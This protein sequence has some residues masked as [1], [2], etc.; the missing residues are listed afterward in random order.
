MGPFKRV[1]VLGFDGLDP[2]V[3][4]TLMNRGTLPNFSRLRSEGTFA[5]LQTSVPPESPVAWMC[6]ATGMNPG[7]HGIFDFIGR[8][9]R[10]YMPRLS[11]LRPSLKVRL[12]LSLQAYEPPTR[13]KAFWDILSQRGTEVTVIR[14]P[15]TFPPHAVNGRMLS[16]LGTPDVTGTLGRYTFYTTAPADPADRAADRVVTVNWK[17]GAIRTTL[18]GPPAPSLTKAGRS[19][20]ALHIERAGG[21]ALRIAVGEAPAV[22]LRAG[23]WSGWIGVRFPLGLGRSCPAALRM[24]LSRVEPDLALYV[25]PLQIDPLDPAVPFTHPP[26]FGRELAERIGRFHTQG[27]P[28]DAQAAR[29]GRISLDA[30]LVQCQEITGERER[31]F[32]H[33]LS[34]FESGLLAAVFDTSDRIQHMFWERQHHSPASPQPLDSR[35]V[36]HYRRMD[37]VLGRALQAAGG[38]TALFVLSDHGFT[39]FAR[40]VH[41]N[42]WLVQ[43]GF[44]AL[45]D[46]AGGEGAPLLKSVDWWKTRAY[47]AGFCS[48]YLNLRGR[49]R[50]GILREGRERDRTIEELSNALLAWRDPKTGGPVVRTVYLGEKVFWGERVRE[51]P[52][53]VIGYHPGYRASWQTALGAAP[54]GDPLVDNDDL[55]I[56]DHLVDAPCVPGV[57]LSNLRCPVEAPRLVDIAP[58]VL[59]AFGL[60]GEQDMDGRPLL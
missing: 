19:S 31:M 43:N 49:E 3:L 21:D 54:A 57:F 7:R 15:V 35:I 11:I 32:E 28:E 26:E 1:L 37:K 16:G 55:W 51:A 20:V 8:D 60:E 27:L 5:R 48:C 56:G 12:G 23:E 22:V 24:H 59:K 18:P 39:R 10:T 30:F 42:T 50:K 6:A 25:S 45:Q 58:T 46:S 33:V 2:T 44:M 29:H 38:E 47:A 52:D 9:P 36:E 14:W 17:D 4:E 40:A 41:L 53:L 34:G 13:R